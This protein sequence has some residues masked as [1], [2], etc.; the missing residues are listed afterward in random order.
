M[1]SRKEKEPCGAVSLDLLTEAAAHPE[2]T[3][4]PVREHLESCPACRAW[5]DQIAGDLASLTTM[6]ARFTPA[7]S[8]SV[9]IPDKS[10]ARV[11]PFRPRPVLALA[12]AAALVLTLA[13]HWFTAAPPGATPGLPS[14]PETVAVAETSGEETIYAD[15]ILPPVYLEIAGEDAQDAEEDFSEYQGADADSEPW[16][17]LDPGTDMS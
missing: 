5:V 10:P 4:E 15:N 17:D 11:I 8:R 7:L 9:R 13:V 2:G 16:P 14:G 12:L 6:A 3:L 1:N